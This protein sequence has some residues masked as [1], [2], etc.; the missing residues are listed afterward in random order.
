MATDSIQLII[1]WAGYVMLP[2]FAAIS[3]I[4]G[5]SSSGLLYWTLGIVGALIFWLETKRRQLARIDSMPVTA[6]AKSTHQHPIGK[7]MVMSFRRQ[8][9]VWT[10]A[11]IPGYTIRKWE[12]MT[13]AEDTVFR[14]G[15][16]VDEFQK[17]MAEVV[18]MPEWVD[19]TLLDEGCRFF[20]QV[21]PFVFFGFSWAVMGGMGAESASA[22]LLRSRYWAEQ[23]AKGK[24]DTWLRLRETACWLYDVAAHGSE[25]F[26][27]G[28]VAFNACSH[29]RFLHCRTRATVKKSGSW[30]EE[31]EK[32][33]EPINQVQLIGTLL[34]SSVLLL[35]GMEELA[36]LPLPPRKKE[37]FI[38]L[39]RVIGFLFGISDDL[40]PNR[41]F[42]HSRIVMESVFCEGIPSAPDPALTAKLVSH[43]CE[44]VAHGICHEFGV[45]ASAGMIA[46]GPWHFLGRSYG[47]A[48]GLPQAKKWELFLGGCRICFLR[49][50]FLP[51]FLL[52]G[53]PRLYERV[54]GF[55]FSKMVHAIRS[56][57]PHCRFGD[58]CPMSGGRLGSSGTAC[59]FLASKTRRSVKRKVGME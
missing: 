23:G 9:F 14:L 36:G 37:A 18:E 50:V 40:N 15:T 29:V 20:V 21:W 24:L 33:G 25:G 42:E 49:L 12:L 44:S 4:F 6:H 13:D 55:G 56:A 10:D 58:V 57:Q 11:H 48:I 35:Q 45:P 2:T 38:H 19:W 17:R 8:S 16:T 34:G 7:Q 3:V 41:S 52:P 47:S 59:P 51:Y 32:Y 54:M 39:W 46:A 43:L 22:V 53:A 28:G 31:H 5:L 27:P 30:E 26:V 1:A